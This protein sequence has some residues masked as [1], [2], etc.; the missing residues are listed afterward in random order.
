MDCKKM[1]VMT[2]ECTGEISF[3]HEKKVQKGSDWEREG[4]L[5]KQGCKAI[6][7]FTHQTPGGELGTFR[8]VLDQA[9]E[10]WKIR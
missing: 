6:D 2:M 3:K 1:G 10:N 7:R 9:T 5:K 8:Q 4:D